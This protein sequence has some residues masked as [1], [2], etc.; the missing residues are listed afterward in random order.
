MMVGNITFSIYP[1]VGVSEYAKWPALFPNGGW[2][3]YFLYSWVKVSGYVM[4]LGI[5]PMMVETIILSIRGYV[6]RPGL[7]PNDGWNHYFVYLF[8]G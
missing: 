2:N 1:W 6:M 7:F 5:F 4:R 8:M 3:H